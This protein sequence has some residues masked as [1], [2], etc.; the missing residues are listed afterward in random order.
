MLHIERC[1]VSVYLA[2]SRPCKLVCKFPKLAHSAKLLPLSAHSN[3]VVDLF[4][5][6]CLCTRAS[7]NLVSLLHLVP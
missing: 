4:G 1:K 3:L 6:A 5:C 2:T 7:L